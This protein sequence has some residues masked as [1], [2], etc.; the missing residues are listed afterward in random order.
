M[1]EV[2]VLNEMKIQEGLIG[3]KK[4]KLSTRH[5][6]MR[7]L[8]RGKEYMDANFMKDPK[9]SEVAQIAMMAEHFFFRNFKQAFNISPY[10]Y[11]LSRKIEYAR[12]L[13]LKNEQN[14]GQI[15]LFTGFSDI[16]TFSKAFK[17]QV[18]ISPSMI[19]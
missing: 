8:L 18:G 5:E 19:K 12:E 4:I 2:I 6:I 7:R 9:I 16:H 3:L 1:A 11:I 15:A 13:I 14:I 17:R 10:Q